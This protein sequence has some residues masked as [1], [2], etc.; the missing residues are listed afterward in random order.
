MRDGGRASQRKSFAYVALSAALL[1]GSNSSV[2]SEIDLREKVA[3]VWAGRKAGTTTEV[4]D[5]KNNVVCRDTWFAKGIG[6]FAASL[7]NC[8]ED[9]I[10]DVRF[11]ELAVTRINGCKF[12][13]E[14]KGI[15]YEKN[16]KRLFSSRVLL[17]FA[18]IN[19]TSISMITDGPRS[20]PRLKGH[21]AFCLD[22]SCVGTRCITP[23]GCDDQSSV[24]FVAATPQQLLDWRSRLEEIKNRCVG[25]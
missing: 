11:T 13:I 7:D 23:V 6:V 2:A 21:Q 5:I 12:L 19:L 25:R 20:Q 18:R 8:R 4:R 16:T 3:Y 10:D 22:A 17:D 9:V 15:A 24:N 1:I 14:D